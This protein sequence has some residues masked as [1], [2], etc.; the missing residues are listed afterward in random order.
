MFLGVASQITT[1]IQKELANLYVFFFH[2]PES[3]SRFDE[4]V[5]V[6]VCNINTNI[7]TRLR[8]MVSCCHDLKKKKEKTSATS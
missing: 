7:T 2:S 5:C 3:C 4:A 8:E 1:D 6:C